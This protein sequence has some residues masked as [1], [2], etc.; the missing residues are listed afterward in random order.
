M[1]EKTQWQRFE[2]YVDHLTKTCGKTEQYK[3][4][5]MGRHGE[6]YHN[7][8][9]AFYGTQAWD[10]RQ[11][12]GL[13][14]ESDCVLT[15]VQC[16]WSKLNSN[17]T[18]S[19]ADAH[20]TPKGEA[21]ALIAHSFWKD[22]LVKAKIPAPQKYYSS[23][24]HRCVATANLTFE[25]LDLPAKRPFKPIIKE[26][27]LMVSA[28]C[29][30]ELIPTCSSC[31]KRLEFILVIAALP[32]LQSVLTGPIFLLKTTSQRTIPCGCPTYANRIRT[33]TLG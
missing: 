25:G 32:K 7:V 29:V 31:A 21:Q 5:Y 22:A 1:G 14:E 23:P 16:Y 33:W 24:L 9:E 3:V 28:R 19:W 8:A 11:M 17:D 30:Q 13:G 15:L 12:P 4:I 20:L 10:V 18:I 27:N 6:G 2:H 26:V